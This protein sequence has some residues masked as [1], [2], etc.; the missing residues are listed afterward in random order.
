MAGEV[1]MADL[2]ERHEVR[3]RGPDHTIVFVADSDDGK[4]SIRQEQD[5]A[6]S[7][8]VCAITLADPTELRAFFRGLRRMLEALGQDL[9]PEGQPPKAGAAVRKPTRPDDEDREALIAQARERNPQAFAPWSREEE[10][11][12]LRRYS[13]GASIA[14]IAK[15]RSRSP[16]AIELRLRRLGALQPDVSV[17]SQLSSQSSKRR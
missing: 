12:I 7:K 4:L 14:S 17:G 11:E 9:E 6:G 1:F 5:G 8:R 2:S 15:A 3:V 16:R 13:G 10:Q